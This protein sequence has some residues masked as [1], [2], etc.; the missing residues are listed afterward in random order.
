MEGECSESYIVEGT[1]CILT[2][3]SHNKVSRDSIPQH[4]TIFLALQRGVRWG[5]ELSFP[6]HSA[7]TVVP[8]PGSVL[9]QP[10]GQALLHRVGEN[11]R[12]AVELGADNAGCV[13]SWCCGE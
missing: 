13:G 8:W 9:Q 12:M 3:P 4:C 6:L 1:P 7:R 2:M 10:S 11:L 5:V